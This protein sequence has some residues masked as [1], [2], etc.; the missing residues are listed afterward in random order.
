M[1]S[2]RVLILSGPGLLAQGMRS[3]LE[4][5]PD[6]EIVGITSDMGRAAE[7]I[8]ERQPGV[9]VVDG[10]LFRI[11]LGDRHREIRLDKVRT[12][13]SL[14]QEDNLARVCHIE[15]K[16]LKEVEDLIEAMSE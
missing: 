3:L 12:L 6:I 8:R 13:I 11:G 5:D 15:D 2:R 14:S 9:V 1:E 16:P 7:I 4:L 10:D